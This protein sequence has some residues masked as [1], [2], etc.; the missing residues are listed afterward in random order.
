MINIKNEQDIICMKK[1]GAVVRDTLNLIETLIKPGITTKYLDL[2]AEKYI[3]KCGAISSF[4]GYCGFPATLCISLNNEVIHGIPSDKL[5]KDG[6][7]VSVDCGAKICGFHADAA[8]TFIVGEVSDEIK[9]LVDVTRQSFFEALEFV[10]EGNRVGDISNS[11]QSYVESK[12][13]S[14]VKSFTG[15][16][17]GKELHEPPEIPN[18]GN[19]G[20]G[21]VLKKGMALAIEPMVNIG[22]EHIRILEDDWTVVTR[23]GSLSAHYENTVIIIEDGIEVITL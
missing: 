23:D 7:V 12:G 11:I 20:M 4:K 2:E 1:A 18:F 8:R 5:I 21:M 15:H 17:V 14:V 10:K 13:Y 3:L 6:D 9:D 22:T 19:K 16:G